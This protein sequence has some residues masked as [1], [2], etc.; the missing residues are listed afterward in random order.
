MNAN[1]TEHSTH[2]LHTLFVCNFSFFNLVSLS[3]KNYVLVSKQ[4]LYKGKAEQ[5][6][7]QKLF[8]W[9]RDALIHLLHANTKIAYLTTHTGIFP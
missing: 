7:H 1:I 2:T 4:E 6:T 5:H 9:F 3:L 8:D